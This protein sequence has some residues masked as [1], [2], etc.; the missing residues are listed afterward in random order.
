MNCNVQEATLREAAVAGTPP[1]PS[2]RGRISLP[3]P[4]GRGTD[5]NHRILSSSRV[6][7]QVY[8]GKPVPSPTSNSGP[9]QH[10][11]QLSVCTSHGK[12]WPT[13]SL[14]NIRHPILLAPFLQSK[15][16]TRGPYKV[17]PTAGRVKGARAEFQLQERGRVTEEPSHTWVSG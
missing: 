16:T 12:P 13:K 4:Y 2:P 9:F 10:S 8:E 3:V 5:I 7:M 6:E 15:R 11:H 1:E 17:P 14:Q